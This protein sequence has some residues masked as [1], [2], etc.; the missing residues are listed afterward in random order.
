MKRP[1]AVDIIQQDVLMHWR[2]VGRGKRGVGRGEREEG[3][4]ERELGVG[5]GEWRMQIN[6][7]LHVESDSTHKRRVN[8][9]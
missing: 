7:T 6:K 3:S 1:Y 9:E 5:S 4:G 2:G 8:V